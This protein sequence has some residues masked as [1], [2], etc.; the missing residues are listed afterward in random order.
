MGYYGNGEDH[1][2]KNGGFQ[3]EVV[4]KGLVVVT[5]FHDLISS[6]AIYSTVL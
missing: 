2:K 4:P 5:P 1:D 3:L 6:C